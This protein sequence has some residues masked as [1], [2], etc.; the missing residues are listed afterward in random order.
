[1]DFKKTKIS[2]FMLHTKLAEHEELKPKLLEL[3]KDAPGENCV[4]KDSYYT[5][6]ITWTDWPYSNDLNRPWVKLF[7]EYFTPYWGEAAHELGYA[8][9]KIKS[10]WFQRYNKNSFHNWHTHGRNYTG[11]YYLKMPE[12]SAKTE[13]V[14]LTDLKTVWTYEAKEGDVIFFPCYLIHR[15]CLQPIEEEKVII[16]WNLDF[17]TIRPDILKLGKTY[18]PSALIHNSDLSK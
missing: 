10:V 8:Q 4:L 17:N 1:M 5:D 6:N 9:Q 14:D 2:S 13:F 3:Q 12:G 15:G 7:M 18:D 16:S 11:V